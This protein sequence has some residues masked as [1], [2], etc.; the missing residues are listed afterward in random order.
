MTTTLKDELAKSNKLDFGL[1]RRIAQLSDDGG[2]KTLM[3]I[4]VRAAADL[5]VRDGAI[6]DARGRKLPG[7][8]VRATIGGGIYTVNTDLR[9]LKA[10]HDDNRVVSLGGGQAVRP[11]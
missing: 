10:L 6:L 3:A 1:Q 9:G 8:S 7:V 5:P 4:F 2:E 11:A